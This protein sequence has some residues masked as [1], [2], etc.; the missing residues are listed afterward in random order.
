MAIAKNEGT[1]A[2]EFYMQWKKAGIPDCITKYEAYTLTES[3]VGAPYGSL[4][5]T[6]EMRLINVAV[7]YTKALK[8]YNNR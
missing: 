8:K 7:L 5:G 2:F 4:D 3:W 6:N 1:K